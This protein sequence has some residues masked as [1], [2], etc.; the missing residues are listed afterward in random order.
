MPNFM[1]LQQL[2]VLQQAP[3]HRPVFEKLTKYSSHSIKIGKYSMKSHK[4]PRVYHLRCAAY[5]VKILVICSNC[6]SCCNCVD[7]SNCKV[8]AISWLSW[9][10]LCVRLYITIKTFNTSYK[11]IL[12]KA[13]LL[14][15]AANL[16]IFVANGCKSE[17]NRWRAPKLYR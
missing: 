1:M 15:F 2:E 4:I 14:Q 8:L 3:K 7:R 16:E 10:K 5:S 17:T 12:L 11:L 13:S 9:M 6:M